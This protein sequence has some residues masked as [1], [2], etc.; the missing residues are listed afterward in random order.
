MCPPQEL[1]ETYLAQFEWVRSYVMKDGHLFLAT[2]AD[3]SMVEFEP[4][5]PLVATVLDR[6]IRT[7]S[8][9]EMQQ[10]V[11]TP[12]FDRYAAKQ[13]ITVTDEEIDGYVEQMQHAMAAD[14]NLSTDKDITLEEAAQVAETRRQMGYSMI[15]QWKLNREIYRQ[16]GGRVIYQQLGPEPLDA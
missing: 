6:E 8:A 16:Y 4:L 11:L 14:P 9:A 12:L 13:G 1:S 10:A 2:M 5:P 7:A 15:R 3:G